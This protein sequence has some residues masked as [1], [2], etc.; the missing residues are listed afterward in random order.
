M[1]KS[2]QSR[3]CGSNSIIPFMMIQSYMCEQEERRKERKKEEGRRKKEEE[4]WD[5]AFVR[6]EKKVKSGDSKLDLL[7]HL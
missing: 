6:L 1:G 2:T 7:K 5:C 3:I 4:E